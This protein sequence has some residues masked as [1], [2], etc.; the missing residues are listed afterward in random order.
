MKPFLEAWLIA[1]LF[2]VGIAFGSLACRLLQGLTGGA[3]TQAVRA[4]CEAAALTLPL[5]ALLFLPIACWG[6][7]LYPWGDPSFFATHHWP[8][9]AVY[10]SLPFFN[11]RTAL[12]LGIGTLFAILVLRPGRRE[13]TI[14]SGG[15]I[16][17]FLC[18]NFSATD[19]VL[20]LTP[21]F[22]SSIFSTILMFSDFVAA[23]AFVVLVTCRTRAAELTP[24]QCHD[25][26]NLLLA[27]VIFWAYVSFSQLLLVWSGNLPREI[28]W[29]LPRWSGGWQWVAL[30]LV[31]GQFALPLA[32][33]LS[34]SAKSHPR[35]LARIAAI[36]L[37]SSLL[38]MF[39]LV[40]P[41]LHPHDFVFPWR[42][43]IAFI[44]IG[45][46]WLP[47]FHWLLPRVPAWRSPM[48]KEAAHD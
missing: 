19:W 31:L 41:S 12:T 1:W 37:A 40:A 3:W 2:W 30:F 23:L 22:S 35:S 36:L 32:L 48:R 28:S 17:F 33:L 16:A 27:F 21:E 6:D 39:W 7:V 24:K 8:H 10:L 20:S 38:E 46:L 5:L 34:K 26:G 15:L 45:S 47:T 44:I 14:C 18:M 9:K 25:L 42:V 13:Q 11:L 29:Y 43:P 4:P